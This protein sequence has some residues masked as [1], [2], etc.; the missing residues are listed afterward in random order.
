MPQNTIPKSSIE[1]S[2]AGT[3]SNMRTMPKNSA[4]Q[5]CWTI[6]YKRNKPIR[7]DD[8]C[9]VAQTTSASTRP[10]LKAL[11][12]HQYL[13]VAE[14]H[15]DRS[16]IRVFTLIKKS[17]PIAPS[18]SAHTEELRDWNLEPR[19]NAKQLTAIINANAPTLKKWMAMHQLH[20]AGQ[21]RLRQMMS[22]NRKIT[23]TIENAARKH[24][25]AHKP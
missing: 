21:T 1:R 15:E 9:L 16:K 18:W 12:N 6:L 4:R 2:N 20:H 7:M 14:F 3:E 10:W 24:L 13:N 8:L 17:G 19:I 25:H 22:G 11:E 5:R 23:A